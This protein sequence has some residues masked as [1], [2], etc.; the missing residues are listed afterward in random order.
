MYAMVRIEVDKFD[1]QIT[2][3]VSFMRLLLEEENIVVLPGCA[4]G[5]VGGSPDVIDK[6]DST[7]NYV[8]RVV[9]CAPESILKM[10]SRRIS[11]FC[12]RHKS[13]N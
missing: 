6:A 4:F 12:Q 2:D 13:L 1:N 3:D 7:S 10:A 8:F 11:S 5:L 9:F